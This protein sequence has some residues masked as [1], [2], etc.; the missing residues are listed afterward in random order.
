M[1]LIGVGSPKGG[2]AKSTLAVSL[3][4]LVAQ[5]APDLDVAVIDADEN[6]TAV[7]WIEAGGD[8]FPVRVSTA[9]TTRVLRR[10]RDADLP[11]AF[12]DLPG[13]RKGGELRALLQGHDGT[14]VVDFLLVPTQAT[15]GDVRV[16]LDAVTSDIAPS[17][18]P[19]RVVLTRVPAAEVPAAVEQIGVLDGAGV[20]TIRTPM[21]EYVAWRS[22][23]NAGVPVTRIGGAADRAR[24]A[25]D[26]LR[27]IAREVL[28]LA[29]VQ[30]P[31]PDTDRTPRRRLV[32]LTATTPAPE[33][34]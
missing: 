21:R 25:E 27:A 26:D 32:A 23:N 7:D 8:D 18:I 10:L 30:V 1:T 15:R 12:V 31:I 3:A 9:P 14:P 13:A 20:P 16:V 29:G 2:V 6:R 17:G 33:E 34:D 28:P 5:H 24:L 11:L 22:A 4:A 19:Y